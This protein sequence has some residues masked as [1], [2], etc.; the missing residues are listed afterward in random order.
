MPIHAIPPNDVFSQI[1]QNN[2]NWFFFSKTTTLTYNLSTD[3]LKEYFHAYI[4]SQG[5]C[6]M[7]TV[8]V[9]H[10]QKIKIMITLLFSCF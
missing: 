1:G 2:G 10:I 4:S 9:K 6:K 3:W 7:A 8:V 5:S